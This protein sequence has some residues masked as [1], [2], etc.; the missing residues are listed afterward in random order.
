MA[1]RCTDRAYALVAAKTAIMAG[2]RGQA[3]ERLAF[4]ARSM[5]EDASAAALRARAEAARRLGSVRRR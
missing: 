4:V 5:V 3:L 1:C 2:D